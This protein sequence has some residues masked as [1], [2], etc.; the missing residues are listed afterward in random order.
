MKIGFRLQGL[1]FS[2]A[3][4]AELQAPRRRAATATFSAVNRWE[5][6]GESL[7]AAT[8]DFT[9]KDTKNTNAT[10]GSRE[11]AKS[12]KEIRMTDM[13]MVEM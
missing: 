9:T 7:G 8:R 12:A 4:K 1:G 3:E 13:E 10:D 5:Q 6:D 11:A 2:G